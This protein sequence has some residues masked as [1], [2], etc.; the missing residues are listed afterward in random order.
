MPEKPNVSLHIPE[1]IDL[2][3]TTDADRSSGTATRL[4]I[5]SDGELLCAGDGADWE[6]DD[7]DNAE[8]KRLAGLGFATA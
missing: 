3:Y 6:E 2:I 5:N 8:F 4:T 1:S 7:P